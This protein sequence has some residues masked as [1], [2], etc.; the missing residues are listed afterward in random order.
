MRGANPSYTSNRCHWNLDLALQNFTRLGGKRCKT[1]R[2]HRPS[3]D[4]VDFYFDLNVSAS[5]QN[6]RFAGPGRSNGANL[7]SAGL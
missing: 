3:Q 1:Y 4:E 2:I 7:K 5:Y 6:L